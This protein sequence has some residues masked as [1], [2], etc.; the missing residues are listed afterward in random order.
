MQT[1][2]KLNFRGRRKVKIYGWQSYKYL[3]IIKNKIIYLTKN[4][5]SLSFLLFEVFYFEILDPKYGSPVNI[6]FN[7]LLQK[8]PL[9]GMKITI[10]NGIVIFWVIW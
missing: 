6:E 8:D 2:T 7:F 9:N 3:F 10:R 5:T 1:F 4:L